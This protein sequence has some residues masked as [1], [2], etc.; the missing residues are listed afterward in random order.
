VSRA[1]IRVSVSPGERRI[2]ALIDDRLEYAAIERPDRPDG[3]GDLHAARV[4]AISIPM[5]GAFLTLADGTTGFLPESETPPPR[6]P[7]AKAV[8]EGDL[9]VVRITRAAQGGKGPRVS[10]RLAPEDSA[11]RA[12][13]PGLLR[14]GPGAA[15]RFCRLL[16]DAPVV[17]DSAALAARLRPVLG[18]DRVVLR[19]DGAFDPVLEDAFAELSSSAVAL[20]GGARLLIHPTPALTAIDVDAGSAAGLGG[21]GAV[22][23]VNEEAAREVARQIRLRDLAG[24]ILV[25]F[26]G[27]AVKRR[28]ALVEPLAR[29]LRDDPLQPRL[30]GMTRLGLMEIVRP[31]IHPPL[32]EVLGQPPSRACW[33]PTGWRRGRHRAARRGAWCC[34]RRRRW[35]APRHWCPPRRRNIARW[36]GAPWPSAPIPRYARGRSRSR[37]TPRDHRAEAPP[38]PLPHL[39]P[40]RTGGYQ[41]LLLRTLRHRR[42]RPLARRHL[43]HPRAAGRGA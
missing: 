18:R 14:R 31:R 5:S 22:M 25:D 8:G 41:P 15:E 39:Q 28:E 20:D 16:P 32:H 23:A 37:T 30:L 19:L 1:E 6:R 13:A 4:S 33:R 12:T 10:M 11:T 38:A 7:I 42:S 21:A 29:A 3:V 40:R 9:I 24:A 34:A 2:A 43:R 17:T 35:W 36:Q 27:L 26:A